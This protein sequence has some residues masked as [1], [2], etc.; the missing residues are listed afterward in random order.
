MLNEVLDSLKSFDLSN[1]VIVSIMAGI[2][3]RAL[4]SKIK[5]EG[6]KYV[7]TMPNTPL[8]VN[9]GVTGVYSTD[10]DTNDI[11]KSIFGGT[12]KVFFFDEEDDLNKVTAISGSGPAYFFLFIEAISKAGQEM[13][14]S[15]EVSDKMAIYTALGAS[16]LAAESDE[17]V[18]VLRANVT[19]KKGT[20]DKAITTFQSQNFE[21]IV[22]NSVFAALERAR[23]LAKEFEEQNFS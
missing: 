10:S 5:G 4:K 23:E 21:T 15:K 6:I 2:P 20:T 14:L 16:K 19:S 13:G 11:V 7:R 17:D 9:C 8:F 1:K 3:L 22:R 18:S 12:G